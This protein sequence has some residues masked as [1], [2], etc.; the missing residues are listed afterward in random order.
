MWIDSHCHL[1]APQFDTDRDAVIERAHAAGVVQMVIPAVVPSHFDIVA[2]LAAKA[3]CSYALG[4]H[5]MWMDG[6]SSGDQILPHAD[7]AAIKQVC[8]ALELYRND[9][10]LVA[11][12]EVGLDF[13]VPGL[14]RDR[15]WYFYTEQLK[16]ARTF[17]LPVILHVRK[18]ADMLLKGLRQYPV[19]GGIVHAFNGSDQQAKAFLA[20]GFKLGFGGACTFERARQIRRLVQTLPADALVLET[21]APDMPP[22]WRYHTAQERAQGS[23]QGRNEPSELPRIAHVV[24]E[25]RGISCKQL[26]QVAYVNTLTALPRLRDLRPQSSY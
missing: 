21:D 5:P 13:L 9:A 16:L 10:R 14:N 24:A 1:D 18:S 25:L 22:Q 6:A 4:V 20:L 17:D 8:M 3:G 23:G 19:Q 12:G 26:A 11:I 2:Q 15:Q 7:E